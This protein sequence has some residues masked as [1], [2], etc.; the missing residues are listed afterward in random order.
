MKILRVA[1]EN[2]NSLAGRWSIDFTAPEY[3]DGLFLIAGDT[4]AGK[5]SVLDA[6]TLALYGRTVREQV[7]GAANEVM[8]RGTGFAC[9]E[10]EFSC[11]HG[12]F[13]ASWEQRRAHGRSSGALQNVRVMLRDC[14]SGDYVAE[15]AKADVLG[16]IRELVGLSF[17]QFQRTVMLA[18]GKFDQFLAAGENDRAEILQQAA[19]TEI[20]ERIGRRIAER[21]RAADADAAAM[22]ARVGEIRVLDA[23]ALAAKNA[24]RAAAA[25]KAKELAKSLDDAQ[26]ALAEIKKA[27]DARAAA[28]SAMRLR[29]RE[30]AAAAE[31]ADKSAAAVDAAASA[32]RAVSADCA[33]KMPQI[34]R[35]VD[36]K[37]RMAL[38]QKDAAD[39]G[40][41]LAA[42]R[43]SARD[44]AAAQAAEEEKL[45][46]G[47]AV[48]EVVRAALEDC[49]FAAN[50]DARLASDATVRLAA[51]FVG[52]HSRVRGAEEEGRALR[53]ASA[54]AAAECAA[55]EDAYAQKRPLLDDC[56]ENAQ[57]ALDASLAYASLEDWRSRLEDGAPCPLCG[58]PSH[59]FAVH[60]VPRKSDCEAALAKAKA[61]LAALDRERDAARRRRDAALAAAD[62]H[63]KASEDARRRHDD[64]LR[65]LG[66]ARSALAA[67]AAA[68]EA[69]IA[70]G[71]RRIGRIS[72][73]VAAAQEAQ[74]RSL[75]EA[76]AMRKDFDALGVGADPEKTQKGLQSALDAA[77]ARLAQ[78]RAAAAAAKAALAAA[79]KERERAAKERA[80]GEEAERKALAAVADPAALPAVIAARKAE[81]AS[82]DALTGAIDAEIRHDAAA[83]ERLAECQASLSAAR[84]AARRWGNLDK[85]L[86]GA[87]GEQFKRFA[88]GI[89]LRRLLAF[90]NPHL[91]RMTA[92]RYRMI[93]GADGAPASA[94]LLPSLVDAEQGGVVRPV[95]NLSGG[96]RFQVSLALALG[97]SEM[98]S[99]RLDIDSLFLDEGFGTLDDATLE[100]AIDTLC[101]VQQD[102]KL[103]GV[104][105]HVA[106]VADRLPAQI[107]VAKTGGGRSV[108]SGPG[109]AHGA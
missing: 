96:E 3:Q 40:R 22:L 76:D 8:T 6:I 100:A 81:K 21:R 85:W 12:R 98:S 5:T 99:D 89:T 68:G 79:K 101:A 33:A 43:A 108:L 86:G 90:A 14:R 94:R 50:A 71:L 39:R 95:S 103:I 42:L 4:G 55:A 53:D 93:W 61:A 29:E 47:R 15:G 54:K 46:R 74:T 104:I 75:A 34:R 60:A 92:G 102:G 63:A 13:A 41:A 78:T 32:H 59:P 58:S 69:A 28:E 97:L 11:Q 36:L 107:R 44:E 91:D 73:D 1:F 7:S 31:C 66:E 9:A 48:A 45:A 25:A 87:K 56:L 24:E 20:Y 49:V 16:R 67:A 105:S 65:R 19:G 35:A 80:A 18:Q 70:A 30:L 62:A 82:L 88:H 37:G 23:E 10:V 84:D 72:A 2:I 77:A 52:L 51:E 64:A 106:G 38:A 26:K 57:R 17:E 109:V 27:V 83:R